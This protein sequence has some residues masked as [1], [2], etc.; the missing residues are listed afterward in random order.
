V[1][2]G[3]A[4]PLIEG[5]KNEVVCKDNEIDRFVPISKTSFKDAVLAAYREETE[6]PGLSGG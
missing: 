6:G 5:L 4:H 2:S 1:P 3:I